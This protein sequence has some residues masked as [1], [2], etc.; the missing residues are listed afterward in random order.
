MTEAGTPKGRLRYGDRAIRVTRDP[1]PLLGGV[2][3]GEETITYAP[4]PLDPT[5]TIAYRSHSFGA[6]AAPAMPEPLIETLR[7]R[8][9][10]ANTV[11]GQLQAER[12]EAERMENDALAALKE[13]Q[14]AF[15]RH[16]QEFRDAFP[17]TSLWGR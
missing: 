1:D 15:D 3:P 2:P 8:V 17:G 9:V 13:A 6:P 4:D 7:S 11:Y 12:I 16:I 5:K 14:A 10:Q